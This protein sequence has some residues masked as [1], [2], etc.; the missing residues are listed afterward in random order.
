MRVTATNLTAV[1]GGRT[2]FAG[3]SF[4]LGAGEALAVTGPNGVGKSTLLRLAAGLLAPAAGSIAFE[5]LPADAAIHYLG[6]LDGLKTTLSVR[7]NLEFWRS[8]WIGKAIEPALENVGIV[9]LADLPVGVLSAGQRRRVAL[10]RLLIAERALWLLDEPA[11]A[12]DAGG[13]AMLG[14]V[15]AAHLAGGGMTMVATH[16]D[17]PLVPTATLSL[18]AA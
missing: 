15:I 2:V 18:G 14:R 5:P 6:H 3:V 4:S 8:L 10:A 1:R 16:R 9:K 11:T 12:L 7:Q 13:E 17:L